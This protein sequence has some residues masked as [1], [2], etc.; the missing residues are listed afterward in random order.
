MASNNK[1]AGVG[2]GAALGV[3]AIAATAAAA[4]GAYWLY[5]A[6]ESSKHRKMAKSFML[7]ARGDVL[8]AV[9]KM[10]DID[11]ATYQAVVDRVVAK[12]S[13]ISGITEAEVAQMKKDL[14]AAWTHMKAVKDAVS[15]PKPTVKKVAKKTAKKA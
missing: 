9:E 10:R 3:V 6:P 5:G 14:S 7:K 11:K 13:T 15:A 12:Y 8:S 1:K 4:A 2:V